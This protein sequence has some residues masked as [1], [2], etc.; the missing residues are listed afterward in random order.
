MSD[1]AGNEGQAT[2]TVN[3]VEAGSVLTVTNIDPI[4]RGSLPGGATLTI[5]GTGFVDPSTVT[6]LNGSG[7]TP[8]ASNVT[9]GNAQTLTAEVSGK[10]GPRK[11]RSFDVVV[12]SPD[13]TNAVC[14]GCLK[15]TNP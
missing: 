7:P 12:T 8:N 14:V 2:R 15:I 9:W 1:A 3:V 11:A 5:T 6:F 10:S 13:G 4:S